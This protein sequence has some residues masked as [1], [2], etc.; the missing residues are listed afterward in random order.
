MNFDNSILRRVKDRLY[1]NAIVNQVLREDTDVLPQDTDVL[2]VATQVIT[3]FEN[4]ISFGK[5][6]QETQPTQKA[7]PDRQAVILPQLELDVADFQ[8]PATQ[9]SDLQYASITRKTSQDIQINVQEQLSQKI[10][11]GHLNQLKQDPHALIMEKLAL[12]T[13]L[14]DC[15]QLLQS[16]LAQV[17]LTDEE[18]DLNDTADTT[19][20]SSVQDMVTTRAE[21]DRI[22]RDFSEQKLQ[23]N[24]QPAFTKS[25]VNPVDR[26]LKAFQSDS[27]NEGALNSEKK[28]LLSPTTSPIKSTVNKGDNLLMDEDS[29]FEIP[30]ALDVI[31][32]GIK[33]FSPKKKSPITDYALRLKHQLL[34]SPS[35]AADGLINL[36]DSGDEEALVPSL[37]KEK[38]FLVKQ[39]YSRNLSKHH[40]KKKSLFTNLRL[41]NAK[42]LLQMKK[43]DPNAGLIEEIEKE[44]EEMGNIL[45]RELERARRIRKKEKQ[46]KAKAALTR[47]TGSSIDDVDDEDYS[48]RENVS[49]SDGVMDSDY[50][51]A[52]DDND[53]DDTDAEPSELAV[54]RTRRIVLSED[55]GLSETAVQPE[56][57][58]SFSSAKGTNRRTD[59]SYMFG[60]PSS[61]SDDEHEQKIMHIHS[62]VAR[63]ETP[64]D[65]IPE[66]N[67]GMCSHKLF[68]NLPPRSDSNNILEDSLDTELIIEPLNVYSFQELPPTQTSTQAT[69][70][71]YIGTQKDCTGT[72]ADIL[73]DSDEEDFAI[74]VKRGHQSVVN[75]YLTGS[76]SLYESG[77]EE[78]QKLQQQQQNELDKQNLALYEA[79]IRR[80]ELRARKR[81][82]EL[83]RRGK[84]IVEGEAE[85]S[86]DEWKGIGGAD[87]DVS[88]RENSEDERMIDNN[89]NLVLN[90]D[91]VRRKFMEQYQIKDKKEL[92]KLI[93]DI[94]NHRL[95]KRARA[96][97]FDVE[98]SDEEDE[99]LMAYRRKKLEE[100]KQRLIASKKVDALLRNDKAK[101][102]FDSIEESSPLVIVDSESEP[103]PEKS[104]LTSQAKDDDSQT[105]N[106]DEEEPPKKVIRLD[107]AFVQRQLSFLCSTAE[108]KY[109]KI[110]Q[111]ADYQHGLDGPIED[112]AALKSRCLSN[113][114]SFRSESLFQEQEALLQ[115]RRD[116]QVLTDDD[117]ESNQFSHVFK[118]PSMV[119]SFKLY[120]S[121]K[122]GQV[123]TGSFSGVTVNKG[124]KAASGSKAS[125]TYLSRLATKFLG[126]PVKSTHTQT[127]ERRVDQART[128]STLFR[129]GSGFT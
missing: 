70:K 16:E 13:R 37:S 117:E 89:L 77:N 101:A 67:L 87:K 92:E 73:P 20:N 1:G 90:D 49:D 109:I 116:S 113:L 120:L 63:P 125:I 82:K 79:K 21:F 6:T 9:S 68:Q 52:D 83:E 7:T 8:T 107:E 60:G 11:Q 24:I 5:N 32:N 58:K 55:E 88:D 53:D 2:L 22:Y 47:L 110:Q 104:E 99:I 95:T 115:R 124:Y 46:Q 106:A 96:T 38:E 35:T 74:A 10:R 103:E 71:D 76:E 4:S 19:V 40:P 65:A 42:Q 100:Q 129:K 127:I 39:K 17:T 105:A 23:R 59:D 50:G 69:E 28:A 86:D 14:V 126:A 61:E 12:L 108:S 18:I 81:R 48:A 75:D 3:P 44:E 29:D 97:R 27:E 94:K 57:G 123:T 64:V 36:D 51:S 102:F 15:S 33:S 78:E 114:Y 54:K 93:D 25:S 41:A 121:K 45:E 112:L 91:E 98:L 80:Q 128:N 84:G 85:E 30:D 43:D 62:D 72:Q 34:S 119:S 111:D 118:K 122:V 66:N 31:T 26:L 56:S